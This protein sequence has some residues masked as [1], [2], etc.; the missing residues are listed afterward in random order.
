M[1]YIRIYI[2]FWITSIN[3]VPGNMSI[4][5]VLG[6]MS[7]NGVPENMSNNGVP[8]NMSIN[9]VLSMRQSTN[10]QLYSILATFKLYH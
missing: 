9:G 6:N 1:L 4:N 8:G 2:P 5:N 7:I 3:D 10:Y